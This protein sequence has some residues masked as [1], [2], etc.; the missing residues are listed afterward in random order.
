MNAQEAQQELRHVVLR[1]ATGGLSYDEGFAMAKPL[2][3]IINNRGREI[4]KKWKKS[5]RPLTWGY[6]LRIGL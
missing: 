3:E 2:L 5:F 1:T 6:V 4:A